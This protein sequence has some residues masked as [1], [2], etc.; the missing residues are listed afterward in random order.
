VISGLRKGVFHRLRNLSGNS[1]AAPIR[2][3]HIASG[4][5]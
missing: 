4:I 5:D 3:P 1:L 2:R